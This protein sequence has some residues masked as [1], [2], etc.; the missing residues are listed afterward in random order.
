MYQDRKPSPKRGHRTPSKTGCSGLIIVF[1]AAAKQ[2]A[3]RTS[4]KRQR[5]VHAHLNM[6]P[7]PPSGTHLARIE[8]QVR[9]RQQ[10]SEADC[11]KLA[12]DMH[13]HDL[14]PA[15]KA[16]ARRSPLTSKGPGSSGT[17]FDR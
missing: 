13:G 11:E 2:G 5:P 7:K 12:N 3:K 16:Q 6:M 15:P 4:L 8:V 17:K 9:G 1:C 10:K 14:K